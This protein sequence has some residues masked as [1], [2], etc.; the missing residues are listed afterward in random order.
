[1]EAAF[2]GLNKMHSDLYY[3]FNIECVMLHSQSAVMG[4]YIVFKQAI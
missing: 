4:F 3:T 1:M 2:F